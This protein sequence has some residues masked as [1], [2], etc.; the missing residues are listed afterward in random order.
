[1]L[2]A[3][4]LF[5]SH[6]ARISDGRDALVAVEA[7][8]AVQGKDP[9]LRR[10]RKP[11][12]IRHPLLLQPRIRIISSKAALEI[13]CGFTPDLVQNILGIERAQFRVNHLYLFFQR[14]FGVVIYSLI[15]SSTERRRR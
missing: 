3:L 9:P 7:A 15:F 6:H 12:R 13:R 10:H 8:G 4:L 1:M 14:K 5:R 2:A 11:M